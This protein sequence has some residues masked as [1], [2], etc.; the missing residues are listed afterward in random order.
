VD[1]EVLSAAYRQLQDLLGVDPVGLLGM[2]APDDEY[3]LE[4][5]MI[6]PRLREANSAN[7]VLNIVHQVFIECFDSKT[8]G[9]RNAYAGL[10]HEIWQ[11]WL[12]F[13]ARG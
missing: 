13:K 11:A 3:D 4:L 7:D 6:L 1:N 12:Q 10:A 9:P 8:A 2:G 5:G